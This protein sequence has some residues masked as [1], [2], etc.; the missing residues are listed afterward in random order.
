[1]K[2]V[3]AILAL[4]FVNGLFAQPPGGHG[5]GDHPEQNKKE[6][7]KAHKIAFISTELDLKST[8]AEKFWPVYNEMEAEL[9]KINKEKRKDHKKFKNFEDLSEDEAYAVTER[10]FD[11]ESQENAIRKKYLGI[12]ATVVGKKKA[13]K[14]FY[15]EEKFK[16]ELLKRIKKGQQEHG[17][18]HEGHPQ[19]GPHN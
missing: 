14:V 10:L 16:R 13:A 15:A 5:P 7:I 19:G 3:I 4:F 17:P 11:Y 12:F 18:K 6:R 8:E 9:E 2:N 1:M